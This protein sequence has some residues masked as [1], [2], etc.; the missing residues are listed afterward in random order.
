M[1]LKTRLSL[2]FAILAL[3]PAA[4]LGWATLRNVRH[5]FRGMVQDRLD[6]VEAG[7]RR[8]L[9][10]RMAEVARRVATLAGR[11]PV[12]D[13]A[14]RDLY[15]GRADLPAFVPMAESLAGGSSLP[16]LFLLD[17][18]GRVLS[19]AHLPGRF[20]ELRPDLGALCTD[21]EPR[22]HLLR[23]EVRAEGRIVSVLSAVACASLRPFS[24]ASP[25]LEVLGGV[26][27]G[28]PLAEAIR[29]ATGASV[30]LRGPSGEGLGHAGEPTPLPGH[31]LPRW[32]PADPTRTVT[33][34]D[35]GGASLG[36]DLTVDLAPFRTAQEHIVL[37]FAGA[38]LLG[39]GLALL[40]GH[41]L[42]SR[43]TRPILELA[44]AAHRLA[45]GALDAPIAIPAKGEVAT[46]VAAFEEMR[47][48]ILAAQERIAAAERIAAW[49]EIA[50]R[51]AHEIKNPLTPISMAIETL[52]RARARELP[53]FDEIF[54][55]SSA[56]ILEEVEALRRI[57][58]EFSAFARLPAPTLEETSVREVVEATAALFPET[59]S[60]LTIEV[61]L[62][63][64]LPPIHADRA[65]IQQV[66]LNLVTNA[67]QAIG[68]A[69][70]QVRIYATATEQTVCL[71][72]ADDGPGIPPDLAADIFT[73]YVTTKAEG[74]GLGLAISRR[75]ATEHGGTLS[76][77]STP[78]AGA[79]FTLCLPRA[80]IEPPAVNQEQRPRPA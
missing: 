27:I 41:L 45:D 34:S 14:A 37:G 71:H 1:S 28:P 40:L 61:D 5:T 6:Q 8:T 50:R 80:D 54:E 57:V 49:Q 24:G 35:P 56:A 47:Q 48:E 42:A 64:A 75:I 55:E 13:R 20:G 33:W 59:P 39:L 74:T 70:G 66:L 11:S 32:L 78:G 31:G 19:S 67:L 23:V 29:E 26:P 30:R 63:G 68:D 58:D 38:A 2:A 9:E 18:E 53:S 79:T 36:V 52:R 3:L 22:P 77:Q 43:V 51:L 12:L 17:S 65:Q 76:V 16:I 10:S 72:V 46:L 21:T 62:P 25:S 60:G 69:G 7:A 73:P 44:D 15:L 4:A